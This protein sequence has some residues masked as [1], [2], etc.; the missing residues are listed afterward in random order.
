MDKHNT[1]FSVAGT[2]LRGVFHLPDNSKLDNTTELPIIVMGNGYAPEWQFGTASFIEA[3]TAAGFATFNFDY[4]TFGQSDGQPRQMVDIPGQQDDFRGAIAHAL[5]QPWVDAKKL[6]IWGSSLG[7]GHAISMAAEHAQAVA[8]IAQVPH[9]CSRAAFKTVS[10]SAV[11]KGMS[12]A[13]IDSLGALLNRA[14]I[15]LP[16]LGQGD[17]YG[18]MSHAGWYESYQIIADNSPTWSNK[19]VARSLLKGGDYRPITVAGNITCPS[20]LVPAKDDAGVPLSSVEET[21]AKIKNVEVFPIEGDH[22]G[23]YYGAQLQD[24]VDKQVQFIQQQLSR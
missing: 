24:V 3:F 13:I 16:I 6:I 19:M 7:G 20:L 12:K 5:Q 17:E 9:C 22:F 1:E 8:M 4:R 14:P 21:A 18:V 10:L 2:T 23:V 15:Y 11:G